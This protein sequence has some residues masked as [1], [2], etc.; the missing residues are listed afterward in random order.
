M[1][2]YGKLHLEKVKK[3]SEIALEIRFMEGKRKTIKGI[4]HIRKTTTSLHDE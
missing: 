1:W 4:T 2:Q 3:V